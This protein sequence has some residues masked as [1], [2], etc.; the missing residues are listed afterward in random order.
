[1]SRVEV[2]R[3]DL[4]RDTAQLRVFFFEDEQ[5]YAGFREGIP[6]DGDD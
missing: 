1:M 2:G 6:D 3:I 4:L 5:D